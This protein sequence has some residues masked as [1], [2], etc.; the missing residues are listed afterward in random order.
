MSDKVQL[1]PRQPP[2][3][4][5][6]SELEQQQ[7]VYMADGSSPRSAVSSNSKLARLKTF[8]SQT[9]HK[10]IGLQ[11]RIAEKIED[12]FAT[13]TNG[14]SREHEGEF[15][16]SGVGREKLLYAPLAAADRASYVVTQV[17][18]GVDGL[19]ARLA[20]ACGGHNNI[21]VNIIRGALLVCAAIARAAVFAAVAIV[22][23]ALELVAIITV[24]TIALTLAAI[25]ISLAAATFMFWLPAVIVHMSLSKKIEALQEQVAS[26]RGGASAQA[27]G[28]A[29]EDDRLPSEKSASSSQALSHAQPQ[30]APMATLVTDSSVLSSSL[31]YAQPV[32]DDNQPPALPPLPSSFTLASL[33]SD[34]SHAAS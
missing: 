34:A 7:D 1:S 5:N 20:D 18:N 28:V 23:Y 24:G 21:F 11:L 2:A 3:V 25:V 17:F 32:A 8:D 33:P 15:V 19:V 4:L 14:L 6:L 31:Q 30:H 10:A 16:A 13:L 9:R 29:E 12:G 26:L 27:D 22:G